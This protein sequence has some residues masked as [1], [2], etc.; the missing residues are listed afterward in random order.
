[1]EEVRDS[2]FNLD[3]E[4][5]LLFQKWENHHYLLLNSKEGFFPLTN[6]TGEEVQFISNLEEEFQK[7]KKTQI[8]PNNKKDSKNMEKIEK[9]KQNLKEMEAKLTSFGIEYLYNNGLI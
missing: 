1:M 7:R 5:R 3:Q 8:I 2:L 6:V 9:I 4:L